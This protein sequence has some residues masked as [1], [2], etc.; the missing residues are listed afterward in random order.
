VL[1]ASSVRCNL[2][3]DDEGVD[4]AE[5]WAEADGIREVGTTGVTVTLSPFAA[6][7]RLL[8]LLLLLLSLL[9]GDSNGVVDVEEDGTT[10]KVDDDEK[11]GDDRSVE[12]KVA[13]G[14]NR[15]VGDMVVPAGDSEEE[16]EE[17]D[18]A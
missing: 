3:G 16:E 4:A 13:P 17:E 14:D 18:T 15:S 9:V 10:D 6:V 1:I 11:E 5:L 2:C 12:D 7:S 8:L